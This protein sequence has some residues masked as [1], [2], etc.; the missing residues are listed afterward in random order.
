[1]R[2][3]LALALLVIAL[4]AAPAWPRGAQNQRGTSEAEDSPDEMVLEYLDEDRESNGAADAPRSDAPP[5]RAVDDITQALQRYK[6]DPAKAARDR[7]AAQASPPE[8]D[9]RDVLF[10]FYFKRALAAQSVGRLSQTIADLKLARTFAPSR[11]QQR[12]V[13]GRLW[14]AESEGGNYLTA[15][16]LIENQRA[17]KI[18]GGRGVR[19]GGP[20][21]RGS[22]DACNLAF[23]QEGQLAK[24]EYDNWR[25]EGPSF[26]W[27]FRGSPHVHV[28][29]NVADDPGVAL[30][31][32][33]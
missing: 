2:P 5:P 32:Q 15:I 24:G 18:T 23:Y 30:N 17:G 21:A 19:A 9:D 33:G 16:A 27:Y 22:G 6:P 31:A 25:L 28:W 14:N 29:V 26:V 3:S 1:M 7:A 4:L 8:G 12:Q 10:D 11:E 13:M 20:A